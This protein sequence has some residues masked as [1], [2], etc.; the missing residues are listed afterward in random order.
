M[1]GSHMPKGVEGSGFVQCLGRLVLL[2]EVFLG[3]FSVD[4]LGPKEGL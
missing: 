4:N 1:K 3:G 2:G